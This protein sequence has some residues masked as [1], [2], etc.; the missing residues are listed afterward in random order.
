MVGRPGRPIPFRSRLSFVQSRCL[1]ALIGALLLVIVPPSSSPA[2]AP[3]G[4]IWVILVDDLHVDFMSTGGVRALLAT[5]CSELIQ[6]A[7]M[8][9]IVS[10]GP[11]SISIDLTYDRERVR[12]SLGQ[13]TGSSLRPIDI[14]RAFQRGP[15]AGNEVWFRGAVSIATAYDVLGNLARVRDQRKALV[16]VSNGYDVDPLPDRGAEETGVIP[17]VKSPNDLTAAALRDQFGALVG[18]ARRSNVVVFAIDPRRLAGVATV[19]AGD[20]SVW[21]QNY[22]ATT[23]NSLRALS[24]RTGGFALLEEQDLAEG[25][26]RINSAM[27]N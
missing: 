12:K 6:D 15:K 24:E 1:P 3:A 23:R 11:S 8:A 17:G 16:L 18:Q 26:K 14:R 25:L 7:D 19:A 2:A 27:R 20:D 9:G 4:N 10:T 13:V 21:W 22:W 5:I